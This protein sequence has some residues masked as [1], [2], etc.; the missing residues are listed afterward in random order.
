MKEIKIQ[1]DPDNQIVYVNT[2]NKMFSILVKKQ[3][4]QWYDHVFLRMIGDLRDRIGNVKGK[5]KINVNAIEQFI[6]SVSF[7][8]NGEMVANL[9]MFHVDRYIHPTIKDLA[10]NYINEIR[11]GKRT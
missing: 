9:V 7:S 4:P 8:F 3:N 2:L 6:L 1:I 10:M 5:R 11:T